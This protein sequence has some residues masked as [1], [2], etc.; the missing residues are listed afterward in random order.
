MRSIVPGVAGISGMDSRRFTVANAAGGILWAVTVAVAA[1][2]LAVT[3]YKRLE[4]RF[5]LV[6]DVLLGA[7]VVLGVGWWVWRW[8]RRRMD[9]VA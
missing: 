2:F 1:G 9:P 8:Y 5:G 6:G 7:V 4:A 3:S